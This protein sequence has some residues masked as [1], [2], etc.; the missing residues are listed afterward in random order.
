MCSQFWFLKYITFWT[1]HMHT[2]AHAHSHA[3]A[4]MHMHR[5]AQC[6]CTCNAHAHAHR[7][8]C[9]SVDTQVN[10]W[11]NNK[12]K[13]MKELKQCVCALFK[14][15]CTCTYPHCLNSFIFGFIVWSSCYLN[16][17]GCGTYFVHVWMCICACACA[18]ACNFGFPSTYF[19]EQQKHFLMFCWL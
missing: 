4:H 14:Q 17:N 5:H 12:T 6:A 10:T 9:T 13:K 19:F 2:H 7:V 11:S 18:C 1:T 16:V 15:L 3:Y 8:R